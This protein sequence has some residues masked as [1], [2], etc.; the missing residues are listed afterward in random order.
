MLEAVSEDEAKHRRTKHALEDALRTQ[1]ELLQSV[2]RLNSENRG[3]AVRIHNLE[4]ANAELAERLKRTEAAAAESVAALRASQGILEGEVSRREEVAAGAQ[5]RAAAMRAEHDQAQLHQ[6]ALLAQLAEKDVQVA[7]AERAALAATQQARHVQKEVERMEGVVRT[8]GA[9]AAA[10]EAQLRLKAEAAEKLQV[11]MAAVRER[12]LLD[13]TELKAA[14]IAA[15]DADKTRKQRDDALALN[16]T[17]AKMR[18]GLA[19]ERDAAAARIAGAHRRIRVL[20]E[21]NALADSLRVLVAS[22]APGE[23]AAA[24][25]LERLSQELDARVKQLA[26]TAGK[27]DAADIVAAQQ[28]AHVQRLSVELADAKAKK[29]QEAER[30]AHLQRIVAEQQAEMQRLVSAA[31]VFGGGGGGSGASTSGG[32]MLVAS[33]AGGYVI[34][35]KS[36]VPHSQLETQA[37]SL[38]VLLA[39]RGFELKQLLAALGDATSGGGSKQLAASELTGALLSQRR[40]V[41]ESAR[42]V[43]KALEAASEALARRPL[44]AAVMAAAVADAA[45][46]LEAHLPVAD[47]ALQGLSGRALRAVEL[48]GQLSSA[49]V[50]LHVTADCLSSCDGQWDRSLAAFGDVSEVL[51]GLKVRRSSG[52]LC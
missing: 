13:L 20:E 30:S 15:A 19:A 42:V 2:S 46:A 4:L 43:G 16:A 25:L 32:G 37:T 33:G 21:G 52:G 31:A 36:S 39:D 18:D 6:Q 38:R 3:A 50:E 7:A 51:E 48:E 34:K 1:G 27:L 29:E 41:L 12:H 35:A 28:E 26:V 49:E 8:T 11:E 5:S 10:A 47:A 9:R 24:R 40:Q 14:R 17:L 44:D 23:D 45:A 22:V